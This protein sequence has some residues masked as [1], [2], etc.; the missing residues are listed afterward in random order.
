MAGVALA[1]G[2]ALLLAT[3][4]PMSE[5]APPMSPISHQ[6]S[7]IRCTGRV[8]GVGPVGSAGATAD[9]AAIALPNANVSCGE[10]NG[11]WTGSTLTDPAGRFSLPCPSACTAA[12]WTVWARQYEPRVGPLGP[13]GDI[14][15]AQRPIPGFPA[16]AWRFEGW[17]I[18]ARERFHLRT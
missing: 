3:A 8:L 15:L 6:I 1:L 10:D 5:A 4:V 16:S 18:Q 13:D 12:T 17:A 7:P 9:L 2:S 11:G 14:T